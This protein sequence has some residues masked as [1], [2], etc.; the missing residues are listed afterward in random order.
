MEFFTIFANIFVSNFK[1]LI[2]FFI[3]FTIDF[4]CGFSKG[5]FI[6]GISS[7]KL[8]KSVTKLIGYLGLMLLCLTLDTLVKIGFN[9][10]YSPITTIALI[11]SSL[12]EAKSIVENLQMLGIDIPA[13][14]SELIEKMEKG[15]K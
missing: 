4:I 2:A 7:S 6:E 8:R 12:I 11:S 5:I 10:I 3:L 13:I 9:S 15:G 1:F 14:I